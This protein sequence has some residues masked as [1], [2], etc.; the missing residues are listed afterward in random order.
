MSSGGSSV[1]RTISTCGSKTPDT[2]R[3]MEVG[4]RMS[5]DCNLVKNCTCERTI[6]TCEVG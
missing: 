4:S 1:K 2:R 6:N 5:K 3:N